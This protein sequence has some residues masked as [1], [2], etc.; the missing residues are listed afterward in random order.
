M[1]RLE[2]SRI[3]ERADFVVSDNLPQVLALRPDAII[4]GSFLWSTVLEAAFPHEPSVRS[5]VRQERDL[6]A[7]HYPPAL[8]VNGFAMPDMLERTT[9]IELPW[10]CAEAQETDAYSSAP[11]GQRV[12]VLGGASGAADDCLARA[13]SAAASI[14]GIE[15]IGTRVQGGTKV[16]AGFASSALRSC[17]AAICRPAMGTIHDC[18]AVGVPMACVHEPGN[19]EMVHNGRAVEALGLGVYLGSTPT[20]EDVSA[21]LGRITMGSERIAILSAMKLGQKDGYDRA[22]QWLVRRIDLGKTHD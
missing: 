1:N 12:A 10:M 21:A 17:A 15:L 3:L 20:D 19:S 14:A 4:Q 9:A 11:S 5:F 7:R 6:L 8:C 16:Q 22:A 18:I 2:G 13:R